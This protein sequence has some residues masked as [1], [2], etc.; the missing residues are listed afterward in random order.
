MKPRASCSNLKPFQG[1]CAPMGHCRAPTAFQ[2]SSCSCPS[3]GHSCLVQTFSGPISSCVQQ[4]EIPILCTLLHHFP[5]SLQAAFLRLPASCAFLSCSLRLHFLAMNL[6]HLLPVISDTILPI[7]GSSSCLPSAGYRRGSVAL[8][9]VRY[10]GV[11]LPWP[12]LL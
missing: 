1:V 2:C 12:C 10:I 9:W 8:G 6:L 3:A 4:L 7:T 5:L 11:P